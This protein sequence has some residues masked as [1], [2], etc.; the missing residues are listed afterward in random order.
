V[1]DFDGVGVGALDGI[2]LGWSMGDL[3]GTTVG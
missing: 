3:V 2:S 1:G